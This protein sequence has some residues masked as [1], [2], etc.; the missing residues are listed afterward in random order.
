MLNNLYPM[1]TDIDPNGHVCKFITDLT[2][3][4]LGRFEP[5]GPE[6]PDCAELCIV[7]ASLSRGQMCGSPSP[8]L[9]ITSTAPF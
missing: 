9:T 6:G 7:A 8:S 2:N 4:L 3:T 1:D 5:S